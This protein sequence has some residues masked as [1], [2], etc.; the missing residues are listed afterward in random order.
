MGLDP[1]PDDKVAT[2]IPSYEAKR[3]KYIGR[4]RFYKSLG[5]IIVAGASVTL[6]T[7]LYVLTKVSTMGRIADALFTVGI[8]LMVAYIA[9]G[10]LIFRLEPVGRFIYVCAV[11]IGLGMLTYVAATKTTP[12]TNDE[13]IS[14]LL[15]VLAPAAIVWNLLGERGKVVFSDEYR[16]VIIPQTA[17]VKARGPRVRRKLDGRT[18]MALALVLFVVAAAAISEIAAATSG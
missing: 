5:V 8:V 14:V 17:H 12:W 4:E 7:N 3:A 15:R 10:V 11:V 16:L 13:V 18:K 1:I 6:G 2:S 9:A